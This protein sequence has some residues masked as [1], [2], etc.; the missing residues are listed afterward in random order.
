M[1]RVVVYHEYPPIPDRR[2]DWRALH[3]GDDEEP[4]KHGWGCTREEAIADLARL[5]R[6]LEESLQSEDERRLEEYP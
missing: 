6:E 3:E 2:W 1:N 4:W 5:D